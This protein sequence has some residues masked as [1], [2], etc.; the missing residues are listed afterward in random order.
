LPTT[1][2]EITKPV[3]NPMLP[4]VEIAPVK[5]KVVKEKRYSMQLR[6]DGIDTVPKTAIKENAGNSR[7]FPNISSSTSNDGK[8]TVSL[9]EATDNTGKQYRIK[10]TDGQITELSVNGTAIPSNQYSEYEEVIRQIDETQRQ[11]IAKKKEERELK[12]ANMAVK[13]KELFDRKTAIARANQK[14]RNE[15]MELKNE[16]LRQRNLKKAEA[17]K[18]SEQKNEIKKREANQKKAEVVQK[19]KLFREDRKTNDDVSRIIS[20][21]SNRKLVS[22]PENLSFSLTNNELIVNGTKQPAE[23]H[24]QFKDKYIQK[25]GDRFNYSKKGNTTSITIN[26]E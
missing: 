11:H 18:L 26:R 6:R 21:L 1:K 5:K 10:R 22:D 4:A 25:S 24:R 19:Q 20:D 7:S 14:E 13:R 15:K 9:I 23:I 3:I 17:R 8:T 12:K 16:S 2:K